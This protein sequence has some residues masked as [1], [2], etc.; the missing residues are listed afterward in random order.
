MV[1]SIL[2][3]SQTAYATTVDGSNRQYSSSTEIDNAILTADGEICTI[4]ARTIQSP[5]QTTFITTSSALPHLNHRFLHE[6]VR[7]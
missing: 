4:I 2:Q 1:I 3:A 7:Y 5:Y 6:S